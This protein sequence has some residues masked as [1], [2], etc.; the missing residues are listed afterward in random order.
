MIDL[1]YKKQKIFTPKIIELQSE[2][3]RLQNIIN[4]HVCTGGNPETLA[5]LQAQLD[6]F[7][8]NIESVTTENNNMKDCII[9][10][11]SFTNENTGK[12]TY[13]DIETIIKKYG[14]SVNYK[15]L[16]IN[17]N[18][19]SSVKVELIKEDD[20]DF[21]D[22]N[23]R[24]F[25]SNTN[26]VDIRVV[27]GTYKVTSTTIIKEEVLTKEGTIIV[28]E[29][30][31][32]YLIKLINTPTGSITYGISIDMSINDP[33]EAVTYT[34]D[35]EGLT[36]LSVDLNTGV[37][38]YGG[39]E[40]IIKEGLIGCKPCILNNDMTIKNYLNPDNY[41]EFEDGSDAS[42]IIK[43]NNVM[44]E[45]NKTWYRW[46]L[47]EENSNILKFEISNYDRS[48]E[49]FVTSAFTDLSD[50]TTVKDKMYYGAYE[51]A[52]ISNKLLSISG[53]KASASINYTNFRSYCKANGNNFGM[54]DVVGRYYVLG[55]MCLVT[56]SIGLQSKLGQGNLDNTIGDYLV[57]G[58][59]ND[60]GLFYGKSSGAGVK[61]FGIENLY[62]NYWDWLDGFCIKTNNC[63]IGLNNGSIAY[64]DSGSNYDESY[65]YSLNL[66]S[67]NCIA[68]MVPVLNGAAI[69]PKTTGGNAT[70]KW[71]D[72]SYV[73]AFAGYVPYVGGDFSFGVDQAGPFCFYVDYAPSLSN[74]GISARV[75]AR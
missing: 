23:A 60:K 50:R 63:S 35:A 54:E 24:L 34:G 75:L 9:E 28:G 57:N 51:G 56:K 5:Q 58:S 38:N 59:M 21:V 7:Q 55:L 29:E 14:L 31:S 62:G 49:G 6:A 71:C 20:P 25:T 67:W 69:M 26:Y 32:T 18:K 39:W 30:N 52:N 22:A 16:R 19:G 47:D 15:T 37:C 64:N 13:Q 65:T 27:P 46:S 72:Q 11:A 74:S 43:T 17:T 44:V 2:V 45:F 3:I 70:T 40:E 42:E 73:N 8:A 33:T 68:S 10:I 4:S 1:F 53:V 12:V 41:N 61:C 36:P 66:G 48:D